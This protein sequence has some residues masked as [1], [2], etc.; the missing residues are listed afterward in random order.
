MIGRAGFKGADWWRRFFAIGIVAKGL[1][2]L[3]EL[4]GG[5]L[6]LF[7]TPGSIRHLVALLTQEELSEDPGDFIATR[8]VAGS[9][10]L[11]GSALVFGAVYLVLHGLVKVVLVVALL[12]DKR[13]AYPWMIAVLLAFIAYQV[14]EIVVH[15]TT[16]LVALTVFDVFVVVL[17]WHEYRRLRSTVLRSQA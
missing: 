1:D 4:V 11:T 3:L 16:G 15:P 10:G 13:W 8:L 14:F 5:I 7:S 9:V 17:T 2:G 12:R 6:L